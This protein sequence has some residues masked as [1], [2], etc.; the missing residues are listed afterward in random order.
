[1]NRTH[2]MTRREFVRHTM[3]TALVAPAL[4]G[5]G[6][7]AFQARQPRTSLVTLVRDERALN[8]SHDVDPTVLGR[9]LD[10]TV[11]R[12]TGERTPR[13]AWRSLFKPTDT[14]GVVAGVSLIPTHPELVEAVRQRLADAGIPPQQIRDVQHVRDMQNAIENVRASTALLSLPALK[15]HW[16]TGLGTVLKNYIMFSGEPR[17]YHDQ[18]NVNLGEIWTLPEVK[19]KTRL[20]LVDALR[21]ICDR[22]PQPDPRY[23]WDYKGLIAGTDPVAVETIA[24]RIIMEKRRALRG[25]PW[26]ISPPPL[27]VAAADERFH[28][29][30]SRMEEIKLQR[31]GWEGEALV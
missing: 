23:M 27:C 8:A 20:V 22:G 31:A 1:M 24:L 29:G 12:A 16:L 28:L 25:E 9:M 13:A 3:S 14:V 30:T 4:T 19:G 26:P 17:R 11:M 15:A 21:P 2:G 18:D 10:D 5:L 7:E 6:V